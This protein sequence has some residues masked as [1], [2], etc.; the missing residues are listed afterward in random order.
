MLIKLIIPICLLKKGEAGIK[1]YFPEAII[2]RPGVVFGK[3]D[4]FTNL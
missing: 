3:G 2:V 1:K 4:N